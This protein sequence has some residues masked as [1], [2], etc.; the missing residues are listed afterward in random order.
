VSQETDSS[1]AAMDCTQSAAN[2]TQ[3]KE[4]CGI[5]Y[6]YGIKAYDGATVRN[7]NI[8]KFWAGVQSDYIVDTLP[9]ATFDN[10]EASLNYYG[11]LIT[12]EN[13]DITQY[14][15]LNRYVD[16]LSLVVQT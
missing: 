8:Q 2:A 4:E 12:A 7:C 5:S 16:I 1:A 9:G 15:V 3:L 10:I 13:S 6:V 11:L 14:K